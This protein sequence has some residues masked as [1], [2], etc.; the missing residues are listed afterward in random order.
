MW[1]KESWTDLL[2]SA[3]LYPDPTYEEA[4]EA[5][6]SAEHLQPSQVV[7][8][9]GGAEA[10]YLAAKRI[11]NKTALI[12]HPTFSEY[13]QACAHYDIAVQRV[14]LQE[15]DAFSFPLESILEKL[16]LVQAIFLCRPN[17]PTG[18]VVQEAVL[19]KLLEEAS[20]H[21]VLVI[22]DE[23]FADFM[24]KPLAPLTNWLNDYKHLILLRSMTK[25]FTI[26]GIRIGY[27][28][29]HPTIAS[30]MRED[31]MPW[32]VNSVAAQLAKRLVDE[33]A[34]VQ[35]TQNWLQQQ[36][37]RL[38]SGLKELHFVHSSSS[39][40]FY[41]LRDPFALDIKDERKTH[42]LGHD[43]DGGAL[44]HFLLK[45]SILARHT[46]NFP[47]LDHRG[48]LRLAVRSTEENEYLLTVLK[49]WRSIN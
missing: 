26:P 10:I 12:V 39:A 44:Y 36:W 34:F 25:M 16:S 33:D 7:L 32:S 49:K 31:Q 20:R 46:T 42:A 43:L 1:V 30:K 48:W 18:T 22:V 24:S 23:A 6:A 15:N 17:N 40:N 2:Q 45:H 29:T 9:N 27:V 38:E 47:G 13:E 41:L 3:T 8:T 35:N 11:R 5:I 14:Y 21:D 4:R 19:R 37:K 28:L